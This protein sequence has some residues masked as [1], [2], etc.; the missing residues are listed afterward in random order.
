MREIRAELDLAAEAASDES[1]SAD[2][3][4]QLAADHVGTAQG[5]LVSNYGYVKE[6][7]R[8]GYQEIKDAR[9]LDQKHITVNPLDGVKQAKQTIMDAGVDAAFQE[10]SSGVL[11]KASQELEDKVQEAIDRR[12]DVTTDSDKKTEE[13]VEEKKAEEEAEEKEAEKEAEEKNSILK[14]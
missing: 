10:A 14:N 7:K 2:E 5:L 13:E 3:R 4:R 8:K 1:L 12:N 11:D 9:E 6:L